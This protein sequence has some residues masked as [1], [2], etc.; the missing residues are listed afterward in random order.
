M[1]TVLLP[2]HVIPSLS[3]SRAVLAFIGIVFWKKW[4]PHKGGKF[5]KIVQFGEPATSEIFVEGKYNGH[6]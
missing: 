6:S 3:P 1:V 5:Q 2:A 4:P